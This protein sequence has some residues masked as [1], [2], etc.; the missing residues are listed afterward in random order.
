MMIVKKVNIEVF[1]KDGKPVYIYNIFDGEYSD[2]T[3]A[4]ASSSELLSEKQIEEVL[5]NYTKQSEQIT[6]E[7][8]RINAV[9]QNWYKLPS[10]ECDIAHVALVKELAPFQYIDQFEY[11]FQHLKLVKLNKYSATSWMNDYE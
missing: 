3:H 10:P 11:I 2:Y 4:L 6:I 1:D 9:Y 5:I 7:R 8:E